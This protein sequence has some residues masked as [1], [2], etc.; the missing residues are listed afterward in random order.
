MKKKIK[1]SL[2]L[3]FKFSYDAPITLTFVFLS[4]FLCILN[5]VAFKGNLDNYFLASPTSAGGTMPFDLKNFASYVKLIFYFLGAAGWTSLFA[6]LLFVLLLGPQIE[7]YYGSVIIGIMMIV[8]SL[9][10][11]VLN[12][13]FCKMPLQGPLS[14]V[15]MLIFLNAFISFSKK[16]VPFSFFAVFILYILFLIFEMKSVKQSA[17]STDGKEILVNVFTSGEIALKIAVCFAGGLCG[18]LFAFLASPKTRATKKSE[19]SEKKNLKTSAQVLSDSDSP[20]FA[21]K[22]DDED[23]VVGTIKFD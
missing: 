10:S 13:C 22:S 5:S 21:K 6:N 20:R 12:A 2:K 1:I 17:L 8:S 3:P 18:S 15:F 4:I 16:K 23:T 7:E 14:V 9:F 19:T 11:G